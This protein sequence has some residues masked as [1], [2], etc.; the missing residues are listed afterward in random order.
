ML[1]DTFDL[2]NQ[3]H[4][5]H[6]DGV[7]NQEK[8]I[9]HAERNAAYSKQHGQLQAA[10]NKMATKSSQGR[11]TSNTVIKLIHKKLSAVFKM[12]DTDMAT[13][14]QTLKVNGLQI[15][16][17]DTEA[18]ICIASACAASSSQHLVVS[19]DS[20]LLVYE[21][22]D[23]VLRPIPRSNFYAIYDK[24]DVLDILKFLDPMQLVL[25]G[26][27]SHSDYAKNIYGFGIA[28][29]AALIRSIPVSDVNTMLAAYLAAVKPK[30]K[31][32]LNPTMFDTALAVFNNHQETPVSPIPIEL[33]NVF[34]NCLGQFQTQK[35]LRVTNA[36]ALH[37]KR[38]GILPFYK[39]KKSKRNQFRPLITQ[40]SILSGR[41]IIIS[42]CRQRPAPRRGPQTKRRKRLAKKQK[43]VKKKKQ[44]K[45][46]K[47]NPA[48]NKRTLKSATVQ[49][50]QLLKSYQ[51]SVLTVGSIQGRLWANKGLPL[52][53][54]AN[55]NLMLRN[56]ANAKA[57]SD[58]IWWAVRIINMMQQRAYEIVASD[59]C[60]ILGPSQGSQ[61]SPAASTSS[62]SSDDTQGDDELE[63]LL[64]DASFYHTLGRLL[65]AGTLAP[66]SAYVKAL[67]AY[68]PAT[69]AP[70][71]QMPHVLQAYNRY[72]LESGFIPFSAQAIFNPDNQSAFPVIAT[73]LALNAVKH[74]VVAHYTQA[75]FDTN[76]P[77]GRNPV[78]FFFEQNKTAKLFA[79]FPKSKLAPGFV[80]LSES[81][82][83]RILFSGK[84][85]RP[86]MIQVL[87]DVIVYRNNLNKDVTT[88]EAVNYVTGDKGELIRVLFYNVWQPRR[89]DGYHRKVAMQ[90]D[91]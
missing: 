76:C 20:D 56:R 55:G 70:A 24:A 68:N 60:H 41:T 49:E 86:I 51:Q 80:F 74:A 19:G 7:P 36:A 79:D 11:W 73:H 45:R 91:Q 27:V 48:A 32:T 17:C 29:N 18:D 58:R 54:D 21:S 10:L 42:R 37:A 30:V 66:Q 31:G 13:F 82:L 46:A 35:A 22:I 90:G 83:A 28:R 87:N 53:T 1:S 3:N 65:W 61:G 6:I 78:R 44:P 77:S 81:E 57:V 9:E 88:T 71:P 33:N 14:I 50:H 63:E 39:A 12:S 25:L 38:H 84:K 59:I 4:V 8:A 89:M 40:A 62:Q 75:K 26:I 64:T 16:E 85:T 5:I 2:V 23:S 47:K 52:I 72:V 67:K 15:C 69:G 43:V 34:M